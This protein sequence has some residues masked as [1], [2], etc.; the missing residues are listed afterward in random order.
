MLFKNIQEKKNSFQLVKWFFSFSATKKDFSFNWNAKKMRKIY[1]WK[2]IWI[3]V[4]KEIEMILPFLLSMNGKTFMLSY[5]F[6][7]ILVFI[8]EFSFAI[9]EKVTMVLHN[10]ENGLKWRQKLCLKMSIF[11]L[12]FGLFPSNG[13]FKTCSC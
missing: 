6:L 8:L 3:I 10:C 9:V 4:I 13:N 7:P 1:V 2:K 5:R 12:S 11:S